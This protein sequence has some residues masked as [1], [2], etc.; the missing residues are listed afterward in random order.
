MLFFDRLGFQV[1]IA[2]RRVK[3][4]DHVFKPLPGRRNKALIRRPIRLLFG[5]RGLHTLVN[6][7]GRDRFPLAILK[8]FLL[9][10]E[11]SRSTVDIRRSKA[12]RL[13]ASTRISPLVSTGAWQPDHYFTFGVISSILTLSPISLAISKDFCLSL[14][15][16]T[17]RQLGISKTLTT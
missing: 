17:A 3:R 13:I 2:I 4:P 10:S 8:T 14:V 15:V 11:R 16:S 7:S 5:R 9:P 12:R 1:R 6:P